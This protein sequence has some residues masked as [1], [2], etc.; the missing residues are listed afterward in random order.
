MGLCV[1]TI[2]NE[3]MH[4]LAQKGRIEIRGFGSFEAR[5]HEKRLARNPKTGKQLI[6]EPKYV[7]HFKPGKELK[8]RI[9]NSR[10][11]SIKKTKEKNS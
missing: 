4:Q 3:M 11:C 5:Y 10:H 1:K 7:V 2:E 8:K 6:T 9:N